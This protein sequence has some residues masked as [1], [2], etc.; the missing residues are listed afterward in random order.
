MYSTYVWSGTTANLWRVFYVR[1]RS[2][3]SITST[4]SFVGGRV[5]RKK[6][7]KIVIR[8]MPKNSHMYY[9]IYIEF[10]YLMR[11]PD[12][13]TIQEN[14]VNWKNKKEPR[15]ALKQKQMRDNHLLRHKLIYGWSWRGKGVKMPELLFLRRLCQIVVQTGFLLVVASFEVSHS[16][17]QCQH[18]RI[19][20]INNNILLKSSGMRAWLRLYD[21]WLIFARQKLYGLLTKQSTAHSHSTAYYNVIIK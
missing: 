20:K 3:V 18:E 9:Y 21:H 5:P 14:K 10:L 15:D 2:L 6:R 8:I 16:S 12:C 1:M 17:W 13:T 4:T 7:I 11:V 19:I